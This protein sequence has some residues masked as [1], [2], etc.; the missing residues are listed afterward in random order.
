MMLERDKADLEGQYRVVT[1]VK[2]D[3]HDLGSSPSFA[4]VL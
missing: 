3:S 1:H 4:T 2:L